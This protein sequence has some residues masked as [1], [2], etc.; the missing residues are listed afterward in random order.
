MRRSPSIHL[1]EQTFGRN[2]VNGTAFAY[3]WQVKLNVA[4]GLALGIEGY[5]TI[6]NIGNPPPGGEQEH[7]VGPVIYTEL[8]L[9]REV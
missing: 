6:D 2:S 1:L 3:A 8:D 4:E 5:G 9:G 7:R